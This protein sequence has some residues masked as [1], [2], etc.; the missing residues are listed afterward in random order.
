MLLPSALKR[1]LIRSATGPVGAWFPGIHLGYTRSTVCEDG[2]A[3]GK[4][5][6]ADRI[7]RGMVVA[8]TSS[9][10]LGGFSCGKAI[11][12]ESIVPTHNNTGQRGE[13]Q[14]RSNKG[15]NKDPCTP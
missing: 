5:S 15:T 14:T 7:F 11:A 8:S 10:M 13:R 12:G 4:D 2:E 6:R 3:T 9:T 1:R